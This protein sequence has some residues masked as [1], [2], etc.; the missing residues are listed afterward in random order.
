MK[1]VSKDPFSKCYKEIKIWKLMLLENYQEGIE[2]LK[3]NDPNDSFKT[4]L[5]VVYLKKI[6]TG[7]ICFCIKTH[8]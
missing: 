2:Y 6:G 7:N 3:L 4:I 5:R 1:R 8:W